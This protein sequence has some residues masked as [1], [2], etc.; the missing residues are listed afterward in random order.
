MRRAVR[1]F[2]WAL[3]ALALSGCATGFLLDNQ[4]Q[5]FS[6]LTAPPASPTYRFERLPSQQADPAQS[7]LEALAD[8]ALYRAGLRRDDAAPRFG[9]QVTAR[10]SRM[11]SP[12]ADP[13]DAWGGGWGMGLGGRGIGIGFGMP[14]GRMESPWFQREV[15]V[16]V[17]DLASNQ[18][19]YETRATN[20]GPW[21]DN[22]AVIPAMFEAALQGFPNPPGGPRR[23]DIH[24]GAAAPGT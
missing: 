6:H 23:V 1:F 11:L 14:F 4:V 9:V 17:R 8:P 7:A 24:V 19:V 16:V 15:G 13:W 12:Y 5:T 2:A 22:M 20:S 18:V 21:L 10:T 3:A